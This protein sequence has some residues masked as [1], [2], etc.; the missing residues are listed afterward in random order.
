VYASLSTLNTIET[1]KLLENAY[2]VNFFQDE[3][4]AQQDSLEPSKEFW[5]TQLLTEQ[6]SFAFIDE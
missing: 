5:K 4:K 1:Q 3:D 2:T 6:T